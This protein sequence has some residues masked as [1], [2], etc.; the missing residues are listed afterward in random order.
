[1]VGGHAA[2]VTG[3]PLMA[4]RLLDRLGPLA[5]AACDGYVATEPSYRE[6]VPRDA[7]RQAAYDTMRLMLERIGGLE[8]SP[9]LVGR[10]ETIGAE[11]ARQG[12]P[13]EALVRASHR[14]FQ[15]LWRAI[16]DEA[17]AYGGCDE[18]MLLDGV[19][20]LWEAIDLQ[21]TRLADGY[22][23]AHEELARRDGERRDRLFDALLDGRGAEP[24]LAREACAAL[25]LPARGPY[26]MVVASE[27]DDV[28]TFPALSVPTATLHRH[29]MR[30]AWRHRLEH[31]IG[32]V[33]LGDGG[34]AGLIRTLV[35]PWCGRA[36]VSP[37]IAEL[38]EVPLAHKLADVAS[39]TMVRTERGAVMLDERLPEALV[40]GDQQ[41]AERLVERVL[42]PV[43]ELPALESERLLTTLTAL[44]DCG[45]SVSEAS[46]RLYCHRNTVLQRM[47]RLEDLV[48]MS[49]REP[50]SVAQLYLALQARQL[51]AQD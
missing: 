23:R 4:R 31:S 25:G 15:L 8:P 11:R 28:A 5:D 9:E 20:P 6:S 47:R 19:A 21:S 50:R 36:G 3:V 45:G 13:L 51:H 49:L 24:E 17:A 27:G 46:A 18:T 40:A 30:T 41:L 10:D 32:I 26:V 29:G 44:L 43:L 38:A 39:R 1:M 22:R 33:A 37:P 35:G 2:E 12:V 42:G 34:A 7:I 16:R 48:G 14:D